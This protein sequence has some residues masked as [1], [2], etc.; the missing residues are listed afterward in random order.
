MSLF[1]EAHQNNGGTSNDDRNHEV[2]FP[3]L[4][5]FTVRVEIRPTPEY[6][7]GHFGVFALQ[8]IP[9]G[10]KFWKWTDRVKVIPHE[11]LEEYIKTNIIDKD[12]DDDENNSKIKTFLRQGFVLPPARKNND[13]DDGGSTSLGREDQFFYSNPTDGGRFMNHANHS[14]ANCGPDGA[15]RDIRVDEEL[16]MDYTFHGDPE[17]YRDICKKY[18][19]L[20]EA[21]VA[22][23]AAAASTA[24]PSIPKA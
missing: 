6:G 21:Q 3:T 13:V 17:W 10:T 15:I 5:A 16:T 12:G 1:E 7:Q 19:V 9:R 24:S 4:P 11:E 22:A 23:A 2:Q 20:T 14:D 8:D 18:G